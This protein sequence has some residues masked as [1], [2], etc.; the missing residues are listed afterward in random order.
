MP[1]LARHALLDE[2]PLYRLTLTLLP[3]EDK[4]R[5]PLFTIESLDVRK[6]WDAYRGEEIA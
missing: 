6:H 1:R 2:R 3:S 4:E 5:K